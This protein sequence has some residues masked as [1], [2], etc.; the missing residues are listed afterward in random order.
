MKDKIQKRI[1]F[2]NAF[3][4]SEQSPELISKLLN[5]EVEEY[6]KA[7]SENDE[8]EIADAAADI[9]YILIGLIIKHGLVDKIDDIYNEVHASNMSKLDNDG[10]PIINGVNGFDDSRPAGKVLKSKNFIEPN[11][12]G[13][14]N[15]T[16]KP[17]NRYIKLI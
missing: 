9:L 15:G 3:G 17:R 13:I 7:A 12:A 2:N 6:L 8:V 1:E 10:K 4:V 16:Y 11:I 14:L 5:E